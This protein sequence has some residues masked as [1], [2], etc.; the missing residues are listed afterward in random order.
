MGLVEPPPQHYCERSAPDYTM[1]VDIDTELAV[2][3]SSFVSRRDCWQKVGALR[4]RSA[5]L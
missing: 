5:A 3:T 2:E 4:L 1:Q